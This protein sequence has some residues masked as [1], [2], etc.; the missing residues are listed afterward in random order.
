MDI[1]QI[2]RDAKQFYQVMIKD[3]T[4]LVAGVDWKRPWKEIQ[5]TNRGW[6]AEIGAYIEDSTKSL[7]NVGNKKT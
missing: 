5:E 4:Q 2:A 1:L 7:E 3:N 6:R